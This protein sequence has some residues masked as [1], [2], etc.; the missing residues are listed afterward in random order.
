MVEGVCG[1]AITGNTVVIGW[2]KLY[3]DIAGEMV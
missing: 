2:L 1:G 3:G